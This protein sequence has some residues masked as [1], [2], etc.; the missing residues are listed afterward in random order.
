MKPTISLILPTYNVE[1]YIGKCI[2]SCLAQIDAPPF[3]IIIVDDES[4][5]SSGIIAD[6]YAASHDNI[7]VIHES[8]GGPACA[9]N[10]GLENSSGRYVIFIDP[11]DF[12]SPHLLAE[13][14]AN[15]KLTGADMVQYSYK[16]TD[17]DGTILPK[18]KGARYTKVY[19]SVE[20]YGHDRNYIP[21][22]WGYMFDK[23][24]LDRNNLRFDPDL[25]RVEDAHLI[26]RCI[27]FDPTISTIATPLYFYRQ[28]P[29]SI[30]SVRSSLAVM[31]AHLDVVTRLLKY[32]GAKSDTPPSPFFRKHLAQLVLSF[33][34]RLHELQEPE[35]GQAKKMWYDFKRTLTGY[36]GYL[37]PGF[38]LN[39]ARTS[40]PA[41]I[42]LRRWLHG[43][44]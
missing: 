41:F 33:L 44:W 15:V 24:F 29:G 12:V 36:P 42:R 1:K 34:K 30:M 40:L 27:S 20:E 25:R 14:Y 32:F 5:D 38:Y 39:L 26:L 18:V 22:P 19:T 35:L 31:A 7:K 43:K 4:T 16:Y 6:Q 13:C 28:R 11:D 8:N 10:T 9:R 23:I 3:E 21:M 17:A 37:K 2:D